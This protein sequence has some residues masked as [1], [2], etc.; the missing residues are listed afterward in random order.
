MNTVEN[1]RMHKTNRS[2]LMNVDRHAS[3]VGRLPCML[4]LLK[5][6]V[7]QQTT[8]PCPKNPGRDAV[9]VEKRNVMAITDSCQSVQ[10]GLDDIRQLSYDHAC[11]SQFIRIFANIRP[12]GVQVPIQVDSLRRCQRV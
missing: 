9:N 6:T 10:R 3:T 12:I 2:S 7:F 5:T 1:K 8:R 11:S 4:G